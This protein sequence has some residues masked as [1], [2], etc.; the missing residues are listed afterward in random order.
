MYGHDSAVRVGRAVLAVV[1]GVA[2]IAVAVNVAVQGTPAAAPG[3][4]VHFTATGDFSSSSH[5][6]AVLSQIGT[7]MAPTC[8]WRSATSRTARP[9]PS[10]VVRP[11][12][13][14]ASAPGFP[15]ELI[16]GNHE[17]N[18]QNGNINDF[19][20]CLPNQ[21]PGLVGV[22]GRRVLRRLPADDPLVRFVM[23]SPNLPSRRALGVRR[24]QPHY[25]WTASAS[26]RPQQ[27]DPVGRRGHAQ[28]L[29]VDGVYP[30]DVGPPS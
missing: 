4:P 12:H 23:I 2:S 1:V 29:P 20:A 16:S 11:R 27:G 24:R 10:R 30:C 26:R 25:D 3:D 17:I 5:A 28:A 18:G 9:A 14:P 8:T 22:Y 13:R 21:L 6:R 7:T 15:F 19:S